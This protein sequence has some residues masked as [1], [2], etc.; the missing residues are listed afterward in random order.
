MTGSFR[1]LLRPWQARG[2]PLA[3]V[4]LARAPAAPSFPADSEGDA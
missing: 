3:R 1:R 4:L 2:A